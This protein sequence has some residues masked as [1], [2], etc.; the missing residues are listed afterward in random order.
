[1]NRSIPQ[2]LDDETYEYLYGLGRI[3]QV[4]ASET[5]YYLTDGLG[6]T[7]VLTDEAGEVV[8]TYDYDVFGAPQAETGSQANDFTFAGEQVD[9]ST[10]LQYLRARYYDVEVGRFVSRD[11][12]SGIVGLPSSQDRYPY[13][14]NSPTNLAL[15]FRGSLP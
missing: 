5:H 12:L 7:L 9:G 11:L 1:V 6:S 14:L 2:V 4:G 15:R 10:G 8:N 3:A 13:V